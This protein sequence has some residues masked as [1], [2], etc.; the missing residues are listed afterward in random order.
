LAVRLEPGALVTSDSEGNV[1]R[2][3]QV[4]TD[5]LVGPTFHLGASASH[6]RIW[7]RSSGP[8]TSSS[9]RDL[10]VSSGWRMSRPIDVSGE[11]GI[12]E[13]R[14]SGDGGDAITPARSTL[15]GKVLIRL[16]P[17]A[18]AGKIDVQVNRAIYDLSPLLVSKRV[19]RNALAA[20]PDFAFE[21]G[22]RLRG[23]AE[24]GSMTTA[25]ERNGRRYTAYTVGHRIAHSS[26]AYST[27]SE[28]R[29]SR[30]SQ[31]GY[32]SP[33]L[34]QALEG[35][36]KTD[37]ETTAFWLSMDVGIGAG[38]ARDH[39]SRLGPWGRSLHAGFWSGWTFAARRELRVALDYYSN[40]F[41]PPVTASPAWRMTSASLSFVWNRSGE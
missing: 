35:G 22:W 20:Q 13:A 28:L 1:R 10:L 14:A 25:G 5:F 21:S 32:Y 36:W 34:V 15:V 23:S 31:A 7:N 2:Q 6:R 40:Q 4:S 8:S 24:L 38:R 11:A 33:D 39:G 41:N 16:V 12:A 18:N 3:L 17:V 26:E 29:F 27:Y 30:P 37:V 9:I 19:I